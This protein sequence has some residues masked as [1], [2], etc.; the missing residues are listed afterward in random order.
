M[1]YICYG[2]LDVL[3]CGLTSQS[4]AMAGDGQLP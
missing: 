3:V 4:T 1:E 2:L